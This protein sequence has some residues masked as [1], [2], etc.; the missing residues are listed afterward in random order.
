MSTESPP[1]EHGKRKSA[2]FRQKNV[3]AFIDPS[4]LAQVFTAQF[5]CLVLNQSFR[6]AA[7]IAI[8][9]APPQESSCLRVKVGP[10]A[11]LLAQVRWVRLISEHVYAFGL[12]FL[13]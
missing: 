10:L 8:F 4:P 5:P 11:P 2:R 6:G 12:Q 7:L 13:E 9:D 1:E 3:Y